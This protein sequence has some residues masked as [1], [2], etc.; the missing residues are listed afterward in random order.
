VV[1]PRLPLV[2]VAVVALTSSTLTFKKK[3]KNKEGAWF[4]LS[5]F[6]AIMIAFI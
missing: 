3:K 5:D 2:V 6:C 4:Q 1:A